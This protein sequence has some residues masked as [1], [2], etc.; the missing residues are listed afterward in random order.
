MHLLTLALLGVLAQSIRIGD[1][2][3]KDWQA[4]FSE[5]FQCFDDESNVYG[6]GTTWVCCGYAANGEW[7]CGRATDWVNVGGTVDANGN[8]VMRTSKFSLCET[9]VTQA[10][11]NKRDLC[12]ANDYFNDCSV[13]HGFA[14]WEFESFAEMTEDSRV[15]FDENWKA[16]FL[17]QTQDGTPNAYHNE[18]YPAGFVHA[19]LRE[20]NDPPVCVFIP[21]AGGRVI[22]IRVEPE[23]SG[24]TVCF[25]D[26]H[27]D[28]EERN[29]P[30]QITTCDDTRLRTCFS[31]GDLKKDDAANV[32][33]FPFFINCVEGCEDSD[34]NLWFRARASEQTW[35]EV[36]N[37]AAEENIEMWCTW[38]DRNDTKWDTY[39]SEIAPPGQ[40]M[41]GEVDDSVG[42]LSVLMLSVLGLLM[43]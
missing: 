32:P 25:N 33:G 31:D 9:S 1:N 39:P 41:G 23:E 2:N 15:T 18:I 11:N 26:L 21:S 34:V 30:G 13:C 28:T 29:N 7:T 20:F 16:D 36:E 42:T 24:N 19:K 40:V 12:C 17:A 22:E 4:Y 38:M 8:A 43:L 37:Q 27:D 10:K 5:K 35:A 3:N 6:F 14:V